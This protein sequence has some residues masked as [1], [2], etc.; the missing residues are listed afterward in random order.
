MYDIGS[1]GPVL[2]PFSHRVQFLMGKPWRAPQATP[3][4]TVGLRAMA[5]RT[6]H[7]RCPTWRHH[8]V[9]GVIPN[10]GNHASGPVRK[11][12]ATSLHKLLLPHSLSL[13]PD[14]VCTKVPPMSYKREAL[15]PFQSKLSRL[16]TVHSAQHHTHTLAIETWEL[17]TSLACL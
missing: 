2:F 17:S 12:R 4:D 7:H 1:D 6:T 5:R 3:R 14:T 13:P 15:G 10:F 8:N 16:S 9:E 11:R